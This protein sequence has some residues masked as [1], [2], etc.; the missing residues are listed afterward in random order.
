MELIEDS[1]YGFFYVAQSK[2]GLDS[3]AIYKNS[4]YEI[5]KPE[6]LEKTESEL[7]YW[8][9]LWKFRLAQM[10]SALGGT[11]EILDIGASGGFFLRTA[12]SYGWR[13]VG[14]EPG[15]K[16]V[17]YAKAESDIDLFH[18]FLEDYDV[19]Q[20]FDAINLS[21]VLEHVENPKQFLQQIF[22]LLKDNGVLWVEVPNDFNQLQKTIV[23]QL[24]KPEW[25]VVP[26]HHLNYFDFNSLSCLL[27]GIGFSELDRLSSFP[28]EIFQLMGMDYLADPQ[29]GSEVHAMRMN[30]ELK[31]LNENPEILR[32][33][34]RGLASVG[35]GRTCNIL[36]RK[37]L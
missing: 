20:Q 13:I 37:P 28:I 30:M 29:M 7:N 33:M 2:N 15:K 14:I 12:R 34:Y 10:E 17:E 35:L 22:E 6:Y 11:G 1:Q 25:W 19:I 32:N 18:G 36:V 26:E 5:D 8:D 31:I 23:N 21:F 4:F 16:A 24:D 9:L 27:K 3:K